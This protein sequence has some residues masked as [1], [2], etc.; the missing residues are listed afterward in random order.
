VTTTTT[1]TTTTTL[2]SGCG[3]R[4]ATFE[5]IDCRLDLL[6]AKIDAVQDL[7]RGK[8]FL[9]AGVTAA[10]AKKQDAEQDVAA[11]RSK[12][13]NKDLQKSIRKMINFAHRLRSLPSRKNIPGA[14]RTALLDDAA[15]I[16]EDLKTLRQQL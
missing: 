7:G 2:P 1:I 5:S 4:A 16:L 12:T 3:V 15:S 11:G 10:R 8:K 14:T 13:A 6:V 9:L